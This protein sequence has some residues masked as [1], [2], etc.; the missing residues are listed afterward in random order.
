MDKLFV[1]FIAVFMVAGIFAYAYDSYKYN[2]AIA[3]QASQCQAQGGVSVSAKQYDWVC[4][5]QEAIILDLN[6]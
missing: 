3:E 6:G 5:K 2:L 4:V 1:Y